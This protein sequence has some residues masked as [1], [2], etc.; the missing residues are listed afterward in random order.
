VLDHKAYDEVHWEKD[1]FGKDWKKRTRSKE[2]D[3]NVQANPSNEI[4]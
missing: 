4:E 2:K 3:G 1:S